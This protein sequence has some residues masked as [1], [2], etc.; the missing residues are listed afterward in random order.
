MKPFGP[1]WQMVKINFRVFGILLA[2]LLAPILELWG[3]FF[4]KKKLLFIRNP[5]SISQIRIW[6]IAIM[7]PL[8]SFQT[9]SD[10]INL[11]KNIILLTSNFD[12]ENTF[13]RGFKVIKTWLIKKKL[14][15]WMNEEKM[16]MIIS[17]SSKLNF[18]V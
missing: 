15:N 1:I 9:I 8:L 2:K 17:S 13:M 10:T 3:F 11:T 14:A 12:S 18:T 7:H 5:N 16:S 6:K 4:Y